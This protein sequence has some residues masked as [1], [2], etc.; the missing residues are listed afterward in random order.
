MRPS[1]RGLANPGIGSPARIEFDCEFGLAI[2]IETVMQS[3]H[4]ALE[5]AFL[6]DIGRAAAKVECRYAPPAADRGADKID[7]LQQR[8]DII[9]DRASAS[10]HR[11]VAAAIPA[12][13]LAEGDVQIERERRVRRDGAEPFGISVRHRHP[14]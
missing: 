1:A 3:R 13:F 9:V 10:R 6:Q 8:F 4:N 11:G 7:L 14:V 2:E 5:M 12:E